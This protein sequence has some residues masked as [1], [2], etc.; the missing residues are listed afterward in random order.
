LA[1][2]TQGFGQALATAGVIAANFVR[3]ITGACSPGSGGAAA[4]PIR[5][6]GEG[7]D[8]LAKTAPQVFSPTSD[9]RGCA[10]DLPE[11]PERAGGVV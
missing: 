3:K 11:L 5:H 4:R 10:E 2:C 1:T 8:Y 9:A 6:L 7:A